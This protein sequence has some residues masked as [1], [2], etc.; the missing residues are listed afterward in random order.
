MSYRLAGM[1]VKGYPKNDLFAVTYFTS[2]LTE[3]Y[4]VKKPSKIGVSFMG[5]LFHE[6]VPFSC[7]DEI[8]NT[9]QST[10][11][12]TYLILTKR[13]QRFLDYMQY[14]TKNGKYNFA[15]LQ[16]I[17]FGVTCENQ[18]T[19]NERIPILNQIPAKIKYLSLEPL[20]EPIEFYYPALSK[21]IDWI[22]I[23]GFKSGKQPEWQWVEK[24]LAQARKYNSKIYFK[25]NLTVR[26]ME[27]PTFNE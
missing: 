4:K 9:I 5:D 27:I 18:K 3:P 21:N 12:H 15:M 20:L 16:N 26:P 13:P 11:P 14:S 24:I 25:P 2:R 17:W 8:F 1:N 22:I 6:A 7:I 23:G 10:Y 19:A